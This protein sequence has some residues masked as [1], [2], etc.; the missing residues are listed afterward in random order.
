MYD[1]LEDIIKVGVVKYEV[2]EALSYYKIPHW[3][4]THEPDVLI[5][6]AELDTLLIRYIPSEKDKDII[7]KVEIFDWSRR[8]WSAI[9]EVYKQNPEKFVKWYGG[10]G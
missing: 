7:E 10:R 6:F 2:M 5:A 9:K 4:T 3:I 8:L 1:H